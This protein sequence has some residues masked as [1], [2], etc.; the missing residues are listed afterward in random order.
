[1]P[2]EKNWPPK[3]NNL[4]VRWTYRYAELED[5]HNIIIISDIMILAHAE[6]GMWLILY[7]H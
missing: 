2:I 5:H 7:D 1:M 3:S 6:T 4:F